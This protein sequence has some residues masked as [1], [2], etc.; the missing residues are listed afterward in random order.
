[1]VAPKFAKQL[2]TLQGTWDATGAKKQTWL[3]E[4]DKAFQLSAGGKRVR[5]FKLS[6]GEDGDLLWGTGKYVLD[7]AF[8][9]GNS[10]ATWC[11][12][13]GEVGFSWQR[14]EAGG[15]VEGS[16]KSMNK[17]SE[18]RVDPEDGKAYTLDEMRTYYSYTYG[19]PKI[20]TTSYWMKCDLPGATNAKAKSKAAAKT[21][22]KAK[23]SP[24]AKGTT[25]VA[26]A[27]CRTDP[28]DGKRYTWEQLRSF[29][30]GE[31]TKKQ[32]EAYWS[33]C[34]PA[35]KAKA[36]AKVKKQK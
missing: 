20:E 5:T 19:T 26:A 1:M 33:T 31:Y 35:P 32:T 6:M 16:E 2:K 28:A 8:T 14:S 3:I 36:K 7:S 17:G 30:A 11:S 34:K 15:A 4:E 9:S 10:T 13:D 22:A 24:K 18:K 25:E 29:Y 21:K 23:A 27:E 12:A